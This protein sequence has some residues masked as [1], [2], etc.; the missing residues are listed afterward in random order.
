MYFIVLGM[1]GHVGG[2]G[3]SGWGAEVEAF[4]GRGGGGLD[5]SG[6]SRVDSKEVGYLVAPTENVAVKPR[7]E[8]MF[9]AARLGAFAC[10]LHVCQLFREPP[11][12][13]SHLRLPAFMIPKTLLLL[14]S[15]WIWR[16]RRRRRRRR[17]R[18]EGVYAC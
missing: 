10:L 16:M 4:V 11:G 9:L 8:S 1:M 14:I 2:R 6:S 13:P 7:P 12:A 3:G 17:R 18:E 15:I 5:A